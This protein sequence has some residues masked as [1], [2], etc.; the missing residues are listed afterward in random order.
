M[1]ESY[2]PVFLSNESIV[3]KKHKVGDMLK[4]KI[5]EVMDDGVRA[6][7]VHGGRG[8]ADDGRKEMAENTTTRYREKM[9]GENEY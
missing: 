7:C 3:S 6:V 2:D 8:Q 5:T 4:L 9:V 1:N